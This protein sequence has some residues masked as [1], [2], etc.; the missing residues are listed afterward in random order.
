MRL[1]ASDIRKRTEMG[2]GSPWHTFVTLLLIKP[3]HVKVEHCLDVLVDVKIIPENVKTSKQPSLLPGVPMKLD[4]VG[5]ISS[6]D[7][8]V[9]EQCSK[10]LEK[11]SSSRSIVVLVKKTG[12]QLGF[13]GSERH[14]RQRDCMCGNVY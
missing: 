7:D 3:D 8:I 5:C 6:C 12:Q 2:L 14:L 1:K 4:S 10:S 11:D 13:E 9:G